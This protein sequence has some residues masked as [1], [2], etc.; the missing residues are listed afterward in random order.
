MPWVKR[1][2]Y[3]PLPYLHTAGGHLCWL[4]VDA[5]A[6]PAWGQRVV[7]D[8]LLDSRVLEL[9]GVKVNATVRVP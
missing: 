6:V 1:Q 4:V 8:E 5:E 7:A 9:T 3:C 2:T